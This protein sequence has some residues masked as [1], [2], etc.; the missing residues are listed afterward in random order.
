MSEC[1]IIPFTASDE[2][3]QAIAQ[4][5][6]RIPFEQLPDYEYQDPDDYREFDQSFASIEAPLRRYLALV[7]GQIVGYAQLF[8]I[9]WGNE[10]NSYWLNL[11]VDQPYRQRGIGTQLWQQLKHDLQKLGAKLARIGTSEFDPAAHPFAQQCGFSEYLR[12]WEFVLETN[13]IN[14]ADYQAAQQRIADHGI[15]ISTLETERQRNSHALAQAY[16]LHSQI[17]NEIPIPG[18]PNPNPGLD[19]FEHLIYHNELALPEAYYLAIHNGTYVGASF[20]QRAEFNHAQLHIGSTSVDPAY[21]GQGIALALKLA[22]IE[23]AQKH[24]FTHMWTAVEA[25]N[26]SMLA[27]NRKLGFTQGATLIIYQQEFSH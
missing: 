8:G 6:A 26:P 11:R 4:I 3:Y 27:I 19:W 23:Y 20:V 12:T 22:T 5:A 7:D 17:S 21:R 18:L 2:H 13:S 14:L 24:G 16:G 10:P 15:H 1:H 9:P 25:N